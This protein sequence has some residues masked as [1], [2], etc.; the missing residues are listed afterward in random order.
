MKSLVELLALVAEDLRLTELRWALVGGLAVG[1]RTEPRFTRDIDLAVDVNDDKEAEKVI[2]ALNEQGY[3]IA[4][5]LE[6][7]RT[8]R[9]ATVRLL[10]PTDDRLVDLLFASSGIESDVVEAASSL[11]LDV[12]FHAPVAALGHLVAMKILARDDASRP[13]DRLD[14]AALF[15]ASE[16][17]DLSLARTALAQMKLAGFDRG[18]DLEAELDSAFREFSF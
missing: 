3:R 18:R 16:Q 6:Q 5:V 14:L 17:P 4:A 7:S 10:P 9:L 1:A 11:E 15:K 2:F 8:G 13:Q 12:D